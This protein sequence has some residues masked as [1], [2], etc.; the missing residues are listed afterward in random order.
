MLVVAAAASASGKAPA[1]AHRRAVAAHRPTTLTLPYVA[2]HACPFECCVYRRWRAVSPLRVFVAERD[3]SHVAFTIA[4]GDSFEALTGDVYVIGA[5]V[6][7][8]LSAHA[9]RIG[10]ARIALARGDSLALL[11]YEGEGGY[12]AWVRGHV[13][14]V[15]QDDIALTG[16]DPQRKE[17]LRFERAPVTEWWVQ[18]RTADRRDGWLRM[19][20]DQDVDNADACA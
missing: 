3:T 15:G 1:P 13:T 7:R 14:E 12:R 9:L 6:A 18:I 8:V 11:D 5:G 17:W 19:D 10:G 16:K 4:P 2:R 20:D